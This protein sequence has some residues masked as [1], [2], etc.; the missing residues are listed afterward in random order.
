MKVFL[1]GKHSCRTPL[2]YKPYQK[3]CASELTVVKDS[4]EADAFVTGFSKDY[5]DDIDKLRSALRMNPQL[6]LFVISEEPLWDTIYAK[7]YQASI[8]DSKTCLKSDDSIQFTY[9]SHHTSDI[10]D[11]SHLPYFITTNPVYISHYISLLSKWLLK[12]KNSRHVFLKASNKQPFFMLAE[13]RTEHWFS[14]DESSL[15]LRCL[16]QERSHLGDK[17]FDHGVVS[18]KGFQN[19]TIVRQELHDWHLDKLLSSYGRYKCVSAIENTFHVNYVTEKIFDAYAVGGIPVYYSSSQHSINKKLG[20]K[21]FIDGSSKS[22]EE[23]AEVILDLSITSELCEMMEED[24]L[25][26][27]LRVKNVQMISDEVT[28]RA[29]RLIKALGLQ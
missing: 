1:F 8:I 19:H 4:S 7:N 10:F 14:F 9:L 6:K 2:F 3:A 23:L 26:I 24:A 22:V 27:L 11:Y 18:G 25:S 21:C 12:P 28:S 16:C 13:R 15:G 20:L 17:L 29:T 5:E